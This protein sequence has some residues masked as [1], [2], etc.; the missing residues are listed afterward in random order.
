MSAF[1]CPQG[2][3][4][5]EQRLESGVPHLKT[6]LIRVFFAVVGSQT[7]VDHEY[8]R[9]DIEYLPGVGGDAVADFSETLVV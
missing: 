9:S 8:I 5:F 4:S 6:Q 7:V 3:V 1:D 2:G